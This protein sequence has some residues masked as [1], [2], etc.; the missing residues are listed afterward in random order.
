M[1]YEVRRD[2]Y[3][4]PV[5]VVQKQIQLLC[6]DLQVEQPNSNGDELVSLK[7]R[8]TKPFFDNFNFLVVRLLE[9]CMLKAHTEGRTTL[10]EKD[11]PSLDILPEEDDAEEDD[12]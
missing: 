3:G 5:I 9:H 10:M 12:D 1:A 6:H 8:P 4:N 11:V 2:E 7:M